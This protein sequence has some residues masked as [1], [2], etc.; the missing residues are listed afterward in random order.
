[1]TVSNPAYTPREISRESVEAEYRAIIDTLGALDGSV[2]DWETL[3][4]K[5]NDLTSRV[6]SEAARRRFCEAQDSRNEVCAA[7]SR[8][9][10]EAIAPVCQAADAKLRQAFLESP[11][12]PAL[13]VRLGKQLFVRMELEL[14]GFAEANIALQVEEGA[15][16]TEYQRLLATSQLKAGNDMLTMTQAIARLNDPDAATRRGAWDALGRWTE[17]KR[18]EIHD[19]YDR[20]IRIRHQKGVNVGEANFVPLAYR[21]MGRSDYGPKEVAAFRE[22][23]HRHVVP[24]LARLRKAQA[25]WLGTPAVTGPDSYSFPGLSLG[26]DVVPVEKQLEQAQ[27][28]FDQL[29]PQLGAHFRRM[30]EEGLIDLENRPGKRAG[31]FATSF[32]DDNKVAIFCNSTGAEGDIATL[33]HEMG[34]AFQG[35]ES[36]WI[37]P[38]AV[39]WPTLD[40]CEVHSMGME[41]LSLP[42]IQAFLTEEQAS[43]Y[44]RLKLINTL[45]RLPYIAMV[46]EFQHWVYENPTH[47]HAERETKWTAIWDKYEPSV[48]YGDQDLHKQFR[49]MHKQHLFTSPF[50]YI[51]Y[52]IAEVGALQLWQMDVTD[53]EGAMKA[54][55]ELCR[56]GGTKSLLEIFEA[57]GLQNPFNPDVMAPLMEAIA[58]ALE[59]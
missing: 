46:D 23:I 59:V 34:H 15:I 57:G 42:Y 8:F 45:V 52:G 39:R 3:F 21:L 25:Q 55:L 16:V 49:W 4:W 30:V 22:G 50:Y 28:L 53:H 1:M 12:R 20:L 29:H 43:R 36:Q 35:W 14:A 54:Y 10:R 51:D 9:M 17:A 19:I 26:A 38:V 58:E 33:T 44:K 11:V 13:E 41:F 7:S 47:S 2:A 56:L 27:A 18:A 40:A 31:A 6:E 32:D 37:K 24:V 48:D 5:W